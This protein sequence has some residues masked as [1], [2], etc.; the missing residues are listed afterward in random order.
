M[1]DEF[2][3]N[4]ERRSRAEALITQRRC[5]FQQ[6]L[7]G[8]ALTR[9]ILVVGA[10]TRAAA[11]SVLRAGALPVC[12]D[13]F[14]DADLRAIAQVCPTRSFPE[15]LPADLAGLQ[16]DGWLA[17]G[18]L[19]NSPKI[20]RA[21]EAL[22]SLG[23]P[24]GSSSAAVIQS[25]DPWAWSAVLQAAGLPVLALRSQRHPPP[26]DG[27]WMRKPLASAGGRAV[28]VW[29][30][31]A[32]RTPLEEPHYF[33]ERA[34]G[35][36]GSAVF[37]A[38]SPGDV[39]CHGVSWQL[40][41]WAPACPP[42]TFAWCGGIGPISIPAH[43][44]KNLQSAGELCVRQL[45]L[46]GVFGLDLALLADKVQLLEINPRYPASVELFELARRTSI[47][48]ETIGLSSRPESRNRRK[49][50]VGKAILYAPRELIVPDWSRW[51]H[52]P[53]P[54]CVMPIRD[55]PAAGSLIAVGQPICSVFALGR[56]A[57]SCERRLRERVQGWWR[58]L[59]LADQTR[60]T[61]QGYRTFS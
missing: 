31:F 40:M 42:H 20:L 61:S 44:Q 53:S 14:A 39:I 4:D 54:W 18:G 26:A 34:A 49:R 48:E 57:E 5:V 15:S 22:P 3:A 21:L 51:L 46:R 25:R 32:A 8:S 38:N 33:Q 9:R 1:A 6:R 36:I 52:A 29:D 58:R 24:W 27:A 17:A 47:L 10:S 45:G 19:E 37:T 60:Q 55:I 23:T 50:C 41:G 2:L 56:D 12:A 16:V 35:R 30:E 43:L 7:P 11:E 13:L 28:A 59:G